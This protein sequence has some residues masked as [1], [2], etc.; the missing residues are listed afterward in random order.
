[1]AGKKDSSLL[2]DNFIEEGDEDN[3]SASENEVP[4]R[5]ERWSEVAPRE[6]KKDTK[7]PA[8]DLDIVVESD[9]PEKD[10]GKWV[11]DDDR[12][13]KPDFP[14]ED[15]VRKYSD[16]VQ[17]RI[18]S[19]TARTH[20]E[21]R[22]A[23]QYERQL[24]EAE[25]FAK[26]LLQRNNQLAELVEG[27][28]KV[29]LTEHKGRLDSQLASA[30]QAYREAHEAGDTDGMIA[31][32]ET[33]AK[34]AAAMDRVSMHR[35]QPM[36]RITEESIRP[37]FQPKVEQEQR[38]APQVDDA[39]R[40]WQERNPWWN[41][42]MVMTAFAMGVHADLVK[43]QGVKVGS[44]LYWKQI[45]GELRTRFPERF[46]GERQQ[47]RGDVVVAGVSTPTDGKKMRVTLSESEVRLAKRLGLTNEQYARQKMIE[48]K[49]SRS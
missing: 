27:G 16:D 17:K 12:D 26:S 6:P 49:R 43:N 48:Q 44:P 37:Y 21:R 34:V 31:A 7:K 10:R 38:P 3:F 41:K 15:E 24:K 32:Q 2:E 13:G 5:E 20:A 4:S 25:N 36:P 45:D 19:L 47:R 22:K 14:D 33:I 46:K 30:K 1:M 35:P 11:A 29:L 8:E 40:D 42:D 18:N 9:V 23:E 28:E 39:T